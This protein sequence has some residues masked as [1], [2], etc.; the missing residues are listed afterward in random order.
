MKITREKKHYQN[1]EG[2]K[3]SEP[4]EIKRIEKKYYEK[5]YSKKLDN[6][7]EM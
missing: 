5:T 2:K 7:N 3:E 1:Q 6:I 4:T